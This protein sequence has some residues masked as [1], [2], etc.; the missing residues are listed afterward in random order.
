LSSFTVKYVKK[1]QNNKKKFK[2][3]E[4]PSSFQILLNTYMCVLK[5][6]VQDRR[7]EEHR[8]N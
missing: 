4:R 2:T 3:S 1:K 8:C 5:T 7:P 6:M